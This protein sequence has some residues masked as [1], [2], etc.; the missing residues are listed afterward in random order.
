MVLGEDNEKMSKSR[1]NVIAPDKLVK[2]Y[3]ADV[4]RAYIIFFTR[5]NQGGPWDSQGIEGTVRWMR[6]VW[7]RLQKMMCTNGNLP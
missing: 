2:K 6:R 7:T 4:V 3:G 1:G 5:W